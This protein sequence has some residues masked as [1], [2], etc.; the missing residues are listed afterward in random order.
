M[1]TVA[2]ALSLQGT[3]QSGQS[4]RTQNGKNFNENSMLRLGVYGIVC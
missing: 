4:V 2:S 3:R 1:S